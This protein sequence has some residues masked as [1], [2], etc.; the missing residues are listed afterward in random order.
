MIVLRFKATITC[1][2]TFFYHKN[3]ILD[4]CPVDMGYGSQ[5]FCV[6]YLLHPNP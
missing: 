4:V 5:A 3:S 2:M 1:K 6:V